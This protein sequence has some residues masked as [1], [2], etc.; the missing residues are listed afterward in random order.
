MPKTRPLTAAQREEEEQR[1]LCKEI[2][3]RLNEKRG[4]ERKNNT[5]FAVEL[6][7][8]KATWYRWNNGELPACEFGNLLT[9]LSR[10]GLK[11]GLL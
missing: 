4:R 9:A 3:D 11:L 7:I 6:G 10:A 1:V 5:E 8:A 2:M